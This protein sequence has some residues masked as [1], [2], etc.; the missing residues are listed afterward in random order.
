MAIVNGDIVGDMAC[1]VDA[2]GIVVGLCGVTEVWGASRGRQ[3][4]V[5]SVV[6]RRCRRGDWQS[7]SIECMTCSDEGAHTTSRNGI[8][9]AVNRLFAS[10]RACW[11]VPAAVAVVW[12][13]DEALDATSQVVTAVA[14]TIAG[15]D[16]AAER[17]GSEL[18]SRGCEVCRGA[19]G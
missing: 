2:R 8:S 11:G 13:L 14:A 5:G 16:V 7:R 19:V 18:E 9:W 10:F 3:G 6:G 12:V 17:Q 1:H 15:G 4:G